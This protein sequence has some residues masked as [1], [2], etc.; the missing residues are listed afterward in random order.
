[1]WVILWTGHQHWWTDNQHSHIHTYSKFKMISLTNEPVFTRQ[2]E[3]LFSSLKS[4]HQLQEASC[5]VKTSWDCRESSMWFSCFLS[6]AFEK[7]LPLW[8]IALPEHFLALLFPLLRRTCATHHSSQL[9]IEHGVSPENAAKQQQQHTGNEAV[10][11]FLLNRGGDTRTTTLIHPERDRPSF[12][13]HLSTWNIDASAAIRTLIHRRTL[14][15][16]Q[17]AYTEPDTCTLT[18]MRPGRCY[19][20]GRLRVEETP[21][22]IWFF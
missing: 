21:F 3:S 12:L 9:R 22:F 18:H 5:S 2:E 10:A 13:S 15:N 4:V 11:H 6:T 19:Q 17:H 1:M 7:S 8:A 20:S 14:Y 16:T